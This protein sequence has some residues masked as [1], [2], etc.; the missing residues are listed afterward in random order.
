LPTPR[1]SGIA[2][3][4]DTDADNDRDASLRFFQ[5][6]LPVKAGLQARDMRMYYLPFVRLT[7]NLPALEHEGL[8]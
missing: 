5:V 7:L 2:E 8:H 6:E 3:V 1:P 4:E